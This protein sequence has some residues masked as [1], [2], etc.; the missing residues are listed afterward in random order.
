[1]KRAAMLLAL[2]LGGCAMG[3][4]AGSPAGSATE[5]AGAPV[6]RIAADPDANGRRPVAVDVVRVADPAL[7]RRLDG[8]DAAAWFRGRA[9]LRLE[10]AGRIAIASWEMVP[11]Q[12]VLLH[13]L[14]PFAATPVETIVYALYATSGAHRRSVAGAT[15]LDV[16]L[17][18][19]G[20]TAGPL[21]GGAPQ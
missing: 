9:A 7:A 16:Q 11:G 5:T 18:R 10:A 14:P 13:S 4:S 1:M 6:L 21:E 8:L 19:D 3:N 20:F 12:S 17:Q 2:L 15:A